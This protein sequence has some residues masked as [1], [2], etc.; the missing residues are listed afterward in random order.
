MFK[1]QLLGF[2]CA[3]AF[4]TPGAMAQTEAADAATAAAE[5]GDVVVTAQRREQRL[6][7]VPVS[8]TVL[9]G[10]TVKRLG[11]TNI[12]DIIAG[13][14]GIQSQAPAGNSGFPVYNIRGVTLLDFSYTSEASVAIYSDDVYLGNAAFATQQLFDVDRVE[15]LKGPQGTLYGRNATGGLVHYIS[16]RP[17]DIMTGSALVQYGSFDDVVLEGAISGPVSDTIRVRFAGRYNSNNGW[18]T[19]QTTGTKLA[20]VDHAIGVRTTVEVDLTPDVLLTVSGN[21]SDT[22][23]SEDGR[24]SFGLRQ[25]DANLADGIN[26][27][28]C[29]NAD[30]LASLC[31]NGA[32]FRDP[33]PD[34]RRPSSDLPKIPYAMRSAGG[35]AKL[36]ADLEFAKLTSIT[37]YLW[38]RKIDGIDVDAAPVSQ[39]NLEVQY[40]ARHRQFS[41]ELRLGGETGQLNWLVGSYYYTDKRFYTA[42]FPANTLGNYTDQKIESISGFAQ[43]TYAVADTFNVTGGVRYTKDKKKLLALGAVSGGRRGSRTGTNLA[44]FGAPLTGQIKESKVTWRLGADWHITP[45]VMLFATVSTGFKTGGYNTSFV[46][47]RGETGPVDSETITTYEAGFKSQ[48]IDR[49]LTLNV[50]GYYSD[51]KNIQAAAS[52][53]CAPNCPNP[54]VTTVNQYIN[55]GNA[56]IYGAEVDLVLRPTSD[57]IA[58]AAVAYNHNKLSAPPTTLI[59]GIPVDGNKLVNTPSWSLSGM[60]NWQPSLGDGNGHLIIG[61]DVKYQTKIFFRPDNT[62]LGVQGGYALVGA[63]L[64]WATDDDGIRVE[65]FARNLLNKEYFTSRTALAESAPGTWGRPREYG[66]RVATRF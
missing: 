4:C 38:G 47:T 48:L 12:T 7:D 2:C 50:T 26:A 51:Y 24:A 23:G 13:T 19:N 58:Q 64:G 57:L 15:I 25:F 14:A 37:A 9:S 27:P 55:I 32:N 34:P 43:A 45:D 10:D 56:K 54:G 22:T 52:V 65:G 3:A 6:Q 35:F 28:R 33:N 29:S 5:S 62:P 21:Y 39:S 41:Q 40:Y 1:K 36:E 17:T 59:G 60:L 49:L 11:A 20:S 42:L 44:S 61:G 53:A 66:V 31:Y 30:I 46:F 18:Q 16:R 8:I 63:R